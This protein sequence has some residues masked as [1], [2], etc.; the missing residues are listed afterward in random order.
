MACLGVLVVVI[1]TSQITA[2]PVVVMQIII[3][4]CKAL[5]G[6][7]KFITVNERHLSL[8][9]ARRWMAHEEPDGVRVAL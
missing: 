4:T 5:L 6:L 2:K 7:E 1:L 3:R 8:E 9:D